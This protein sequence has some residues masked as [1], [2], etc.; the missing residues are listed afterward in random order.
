MV[1]L[2][3]NVE[4]VDV[5]KFSATPLLLFSLRIATA[6]PQ[7]RIENVMLNCQ[8][9]IDPTLRVYSAAERER[10]G[11]LFGAPSA[12]A[13]PCTVCC[14]RTPMWRFRAFRARPWFACRPSARMISASRA[15][16][17][18]MAWSK[19]RFRSRFSSAAR[20]STR[21]RRTPCRSS[22]FAGPRRRSFRLQAQMWRDLMDNY[23]PNCD[24]LRI[25]SETFDRL[26]RF[27]RR[28]GLLSF[29]DVLDELLQQA[30]AHAS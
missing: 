12:G 30:E 21:M 20:S 14:G 18:F 8:I 22:R 7:R 2:L 23:Y 15:R 1:D 3:F 17:F 29:D 24:L 11:E 28:R 25:G 16:S 27:K 5:E 6:E 9:R 26:Y 10:L 4:G 13:K 19:E